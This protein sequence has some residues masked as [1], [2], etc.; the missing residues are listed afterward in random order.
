MLSLTDRVRKLCSDV[1]GDTVKVD[2][3]E[4]PQYKIDAVI[5]LIE[6]THSNLEHSTR[7][8]ELFLD[9]YGLRDL[10]RDPYTSSELEEKYNIGR[11]C[12][13]NIVIKIQRKMCRLKYKL[14]FFSREEEKQAITK[15]MELKKQLKELLFRVEFG[16]NQLSIDE[17]GLSI[18]AYNTLRRAGYTKLGQ[19]RDLSK[20]DLL[21]ITN[22]SSRTA[23]E[24]LEAVS[25]Y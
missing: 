5:G 16:S 12:I 20:E 6:S 4:I 24:I 19:L 10:S 14:P 21:A 25:N 2:S 23:D 17:I 22:M 3:E 18:R 7:N 8:Q 9:F 11:N 15:S 1:Y 13:R